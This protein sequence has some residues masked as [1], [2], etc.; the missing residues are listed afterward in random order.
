[1]I[2][3]VLSYQEGSVHPQAH[4]Q[5]PQGQHSMLRD[6]QESSRIQVRQAVAITCSVRVSRLW[7][8][9]CVCVCVA[10]AL[11]GQGLQVQAD[12]G[13]EPNP[14]LGA[15]HMNT[16]NGNISTS[17]INEDATPKSD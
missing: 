2:G 4:G 3:L 13:G 1:M 8:S 5:E 7:G 12:S 16:V 6:H 17:I 10:D 11:G 15:R 9:V 14:P